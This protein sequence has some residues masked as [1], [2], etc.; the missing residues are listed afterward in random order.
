MHVRLEAMWIAFEIAGNLALDSFDVCLSHVQLA[1]GPE[2]RGF[3]DDRS[4]SFLWAWMERL[5]G[6]ND[7]PPFGIVSVPARGGN[8]RACLN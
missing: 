5:N 7:S 3:H 4:R 2:E 1:S 6:S 8:S